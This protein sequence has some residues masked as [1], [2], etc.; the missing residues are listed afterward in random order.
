MLRSQARSAS[1]TRSAIRLRFL[2]RRGDGRIRRASSALLLTLFLGGAALGQSASKV[3]HIV[4]GFMAKLRCFIVGE[5][6]Q[7]PRIHPRN[8]CHHRLSQRGSPI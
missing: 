5:R 3:P 2:T 6:S 7:R 8:H 4:A 1:P